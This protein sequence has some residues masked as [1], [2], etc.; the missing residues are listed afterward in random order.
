[1]SRA[2]REREEKNALRRGTQLDEVCHTV[3]E[4]ARLA[5]PSSGND[6]E[7]PAFVTHG[8]G[9]FGI[10]LGGEIAWVGCQR[11]R[12]RVAVAWTIDTRAVGHGARSEEHTSELQSPY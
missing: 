9:L 6:E 7:R 11:S 5:R 8:R 4:R 10:E 2:A 1:M 3:D 12:V